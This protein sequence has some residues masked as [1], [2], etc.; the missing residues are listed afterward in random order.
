MASLDASALG[1]LKPVPRFREL[2]SLIPEGLGRDCYIS[3]KKTVDR[4][5]RAV[6]LGQH[7]RL[8]DTFSSTLGL[9][10][11]LAVASVSIDNE[12]ICSAFSVYFTTLE[13]AYYWPREQDVRTPAM[14]M[15]HKLVVQ[16]FHHPELREML[17]S[18]LE[19]QDENVA[20]DALRMAK[21]MV[22]EARTARR[23]GGKLDSIKQDRVNLLYRTCTEDWACQGDYNDTDSHK[24]FGRLH[25][26]IRTNGTQRSVQEIFEAASGLRWLQEMPSLLSSLPTSSDLLCDAFLDLQLAIALGREELY[27]MM[28]DE[29]VWGRTFAK[30]SKGVDVCTIGAGGA[31]CPMFRM[32]DALCGR[33]DGTGQAA[34]LDELDFRSRFF[35]RDFRALINAVASSP[36]IRQYVSS[37][38]TSYVL[39]Q[40]FKALQQQLFDIYEM[41]R[42]KAMRIALALR[43]GQA[44]TSSG[45]EKAAS[46]EWHI[47]NMLSSA[48]KVRFGD[49]PEALKIDAYTWSTPLLYDTD[50][51]IE[52]ARV[53]LVF[54]T[55]L[56]LSPGDTISVSVQIKP[57]QWHTRTYSITQTDAQ[58]G[59]SQA[60]CSVTSSVEICVRRRGLVSTYLC[61]Q[62]S[63]FPTRVAVR[64]APHFRI[65]G[66]SSHDEE[67]MFVAQ[68]GAVGVFLPWLYQQKCL[69]GKYRLIVATRNCNM[70]AY[71]TRLHRLASQF[72]PQLQIVI[73]LSNAN[74]GDIKTLSFGRIEAYCGRVT[75]YLKSCSLG[76][77]TTTYVCGSSA[78][79]VD[80]AARIA[81]RR[82]TTQSDLGPRL[83]PVLTSSLPNIR[84]HVAA[85]SS[86]VAA[87]QK[88]CKLKV[89]SRAELSLHNFPGDLWIALGDR[90]FDI[91]AVS[92]FHPGGEKVLTYRA[93]RQA[94]DVFDSVHA[95]SFEVDSLLQQLV[96]GVLA[97][98][99]NRPEVQEWE[100]RLDKLVEIQNDL[101]NNT[102]FEQKPTG[103]S[104]QLSRA[105]PAYVVRASLDDFVKAWGT[106]VADVV[107]DAE[108]AAVVR[109][110]AAREAA[111]GYFDEVQSRVYR[112]A[113]DDEECCALVLRG[114]FEAVEL[115]VSK[116]HA[117]IDDMKKYLFDCFTDGREPS[118][119]VCVHD[120]TVRIITA[121]EQ[122]IP[123]SVDS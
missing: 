63:G 72:G 50:G 114:V 115:A 90:V 77:N 98:P 20:L 109:L 57:G 38:K 51:R 105:P 84:L 85:G 100:R 102:R 35:P 79:G 89:I 56:A 65:R 12:Q 16:M 111:S 68:G 80:V 92:S 122:I 67:T 108:D 91:S 87:A 32:L 24:E 74:Q 96:V 30:F 118:V 81:A 17:L 25:E 58:W 97:P 83:A 39:A 123:S 6:Q 113:F 3:V 8:I 78:F 121:L 41:H 4:L 14:L 46:P 21:A 22:E 54:S 69:I 2:T 86:H 116:I 107:G 40:A 43:A 60:V 76:K 23:D 64:S 26:V 61:N 66:N 34:L 71:A 101:T 70:L 37:G 110:R 104:R 19:S 33:A 52:A 53:R 47:A 9:D 55:P 7:R 31:D 95:G 28:I 73:G 48:M 62:Q 45:T 82:K 88:S 119:A 103:E 27:S 42:K 1:R 5:G 10:T 94:R 18:T 49:D 44:S 106:L 112:D 93:G 75:E 36:S 59:H 120:G 11:L 15:E 29:T 117:A 13:Q 99:T